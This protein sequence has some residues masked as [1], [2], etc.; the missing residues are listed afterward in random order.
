MLRQILAAILIAGVP[1]WALGAELSLPQL[2]ALSAVMKAVGLQGMERIRVNMDIRSVFNG[3]RYDIRDPFARIELDV[4]RESGGKGFRFSG[5]VDGRY[6]NG[7]VEL[8]NDGSWEIWG[9]GL[10]I[11]MRR[12]GSADYEISGFVDEAVGGS[13]HMDVTLR[14]RGSPGSFD[15]WDN[16][17]S[18]DFRKWA[19]NVS[20]SGEIDPQWFG[21]KSLAIVSVFVAVL[22]AQLDQPQK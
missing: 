6:L 14:Q 4:S 12:R 21:K 16:G 9:G 11:D 2:P 20:V 17:V 19:S 10:N 8:R 18:L 15:I 22:E 1:S 3:D 7:R 13:R 5:D